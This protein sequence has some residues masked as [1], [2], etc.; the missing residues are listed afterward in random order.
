VLV[1]GFT[2]T[3]GCWSP[4]DDDLATDHEVVRVDAPGHGGSADV[5]AD[6]WEA[7]RAIAG[8][9]G[10]ATYVGYS[11]G[12]RMCLHAALTRP[13]VVR[14]LVIISATAG[15]DSDDERARRRDADAQLGDHLVEVGVEQFVDEWLAQ[16][17]FATLPPERAH[18]AERLTNTAEGLASSLRL[19]GT[20]TQEPLW[21][22]LASL[23]M[24]VL[25]VAGALDGKFRALGERLVASIGAGGELVVIPDAGHTVHLEQ[26]EAFLV[27]LR[28]WLTRTSR[29]V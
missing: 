1:H 24:P 16:P 25:A 17:L 4:I 3:S 5:R 26:P 18:R 12:G 11:M 6:L 23:D 22:H 8:A 2:Q 27:V 7:G 10:A 28:D 21:G 9:G 29:Q 14:R 20:G 15:I 19:T 13:D